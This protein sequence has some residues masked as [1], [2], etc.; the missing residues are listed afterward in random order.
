MDKRKR[1]VLFVL[2]YLL[3]PSALL[4]PNA[5][6]TSNA[7]VHGE[8]QYGPCACQPRGTLF[9]WSYGTSF[10][11]GP[12]LSEPLVTDRP[13]FTESSVTVGRG[14]TQLEMGYLYVNDRAPGTSF[15][16]HAYPDLLLR[17]GLFAE[18]FEL[19]IGWTYLSDRETIGNLTTT[20]DRSSDLLVGAKIAL[21]PQED[22]LPEMALIAQMFVPISDDPILGGGEVLPG[23]NWIYSW[24]LNDWLSIAGSSQ[25]NRA[26]DGANGEP[27]GLFAQT[28]VAGFSLTDCVGAFSEWFAFV[29]DGADTVHTQHYFNGGFTYLITDDLQLDVKAGLGLSDNADDFFV[30][31]GLSVRLP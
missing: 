22:L 7:L 11:G 8:R 24:E 2:G 15:D 31:T 19:R 12:D 4:F 9:Q 29:P 17:Q 21:T 16:G 27:Y 28:A 30:G 26:L 20:N 13:D 14:V 3:S 10:S 5:L 23:V 1:A 18:W 6:L 25:I